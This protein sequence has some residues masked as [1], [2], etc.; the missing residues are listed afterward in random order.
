MC[1]ASFFR[2]ELQHGL[3]LR[4]SFLPEIVP[5]VEKTYQGLLGFGAVAQK[6]LDQ[7]HVVGPGRKK[8][9]RFSA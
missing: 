8:Q 4:E 1:P 3:T 9:R 7:F 2:E 6:K 5:F